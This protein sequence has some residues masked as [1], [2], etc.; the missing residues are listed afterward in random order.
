MNHFLKTLPGKKNQVIDL[1]RD[2]RDKLDGTKPLIAVPV[3]SD[4]N[5]M[6]EVSYPISDFNRI[7]EGVSGVK[8][9]KLDAKPIEMLNEMLLVNRLSGLVENIYRIVQ[10]KLIG[11]GLVDK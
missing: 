11:S 9:D 4:Q 1:V 2:W 3:S 5:E 8:S 10:M 7:I 6:V